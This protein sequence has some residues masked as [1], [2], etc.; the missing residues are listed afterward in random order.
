MIPADILS[1]CGVS[2]P[3]ERTQDTLMTSVHPAPTRK[4]LQHLFDVAVEAAHPAATLGRYLPDISTFENV[5]VVGAGKAA[6]AMAVA[7]EHH[8]DASGL[9]DRISG[10]V[11]TRHGYGLPTNRLTILEAGHP[12]PDAASVAASEA[13]IARVEAAGA[14]DLVIVL[15]SGGAS[16]IWTGLAPGIML[17]DYQGLTRDLLRSGATISE[18]NTVRKHLSCISGGRLAAKAAPA[19]LLTFAISDVPGDDPSMIGSGPTVPDPTTL[20]DAADLL[21]K[22]DV[23]PVAPIAAALAQNSNET[24]KPGHV[25]FKNAI[26][27]LIAAPAMSLDAAAT[28]VAALGY[29]AIVLG[30]ALEGEARTVAAAH[31]KQAIDLSSEGEKIALLS[32]GELTVTIAGNGAGGPNQEYALALAIALDGANG[33]HALA[34]DTD[35][36][37]GGDGSADDPA[38]AIVTPDTLPRAH[39]AGLN[40]HDALSRNDSGGFFR[41]LNDLVVTGPTQTNVNDFRVTLIDPETEGRLVS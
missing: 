37:D 30:D 13:A 11:A 39:A 38:G 8:Y 34:A 10:E 22:Y 5:I 9:R 3:R 1:I 18:I 40:A 6:A 29:R 24:P 23:A 15:L 16:A 4:T 20:D 17:E 26:Y 28:A 41:T 25:A 19:R 32:G 12:V 31:A 14:D 33:I 27:E 7:L 2:A 21:R 36:T 35:G